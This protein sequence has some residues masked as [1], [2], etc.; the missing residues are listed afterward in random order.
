MARGEVITDEKRKFR[1]KAKN[2]KKGRSRALSVR[3]C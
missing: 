3:H 1:D 2:G